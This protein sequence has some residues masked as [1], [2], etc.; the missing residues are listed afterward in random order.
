M[1]DGSVYSTSDLSNV[2]HHHP[3]LA[4]LEAYYAYYGM[5]LTYRGWT[6]DVQDVPVIAFSGIAVEGNIKPTTKEW[7][8]LATP[9]QIHEAVWGP[10]ENSAVGAPFIWNNKLKRKEYPRTVLGALQDRIV[11]EQLAP[12]RQA[13]ASQDAQIKALVGAVAAMAKGEPFDQAKLLA[14]VQSAA[15]QGVAQAIQSIDTTVTV[16]AG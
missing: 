3:S 5:T 13:V 14:G 7:D 2:P 4:D 9:Q 16:K 10:A 6:E 15:A 11:T 12:L 8:E 1:P